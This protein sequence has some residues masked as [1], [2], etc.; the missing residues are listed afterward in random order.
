MVLFYS[1]QLHV[2]WAVILYFRRSYSSKQSEAWWGGM[3]WLTWINLIFSFPS[4]EVLI[5]SGFVPVPSEGK[6]WKLFTKCHCFPAANCK[7]NNGALLLGCEFPGGQAGL[8]FHSSRTS[9][10]VAFTTLFTTSSLLTCLKSNW[11]LRS[12]AELSGSMLWSSRSRVHSSEAAQHLTPCTS[13]P[14]NSRPRRKSGTKDKTCEGMQML[15]IL[16]HPHVCHLLPFQVVFRCWWLFSHLIKSR[17]GFLNFMSKLLLCK[18]D[19]PAG[20][21][22]TEASPLP[23]VFWSGRPS[24]HLPRHPGDSEVLA[25]CPTARSEHPHPTLG[26]AKVHG[27]CKHPCSKASSHD[28]PHW[29]TRILLWLSLKANRWLALHRSAGL[30]S[31]KE[32]LIAR[33][34]WD[35]SGE[36][37]LSGSSPVWGVM[38]RNYL[39]RHLCGS[40]RGGKG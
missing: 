1:K 32:S 10:T 6:F 13:H 33:F 20:R 15:K 11:P 38:G 2:F 37:D 24:Q 14:D 35:C 19:N 27:A 21:C 28:A 40:C 3:F 34:Q 39:W 29:S 17:L 23:E 30:L 4:V 26:D 5:S 22:S 25:W 9:P 36:L 16:L 31:P 8:W 7:E 18:G 12:D